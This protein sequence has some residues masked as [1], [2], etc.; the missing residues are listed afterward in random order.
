M[1]SRGANVQACDSTGNGLLAGFFTAYDHLDKV[2]AGMTILLDAGC[3]VN[4]TDLRGITA[5]N[6]AQQGWHRG[7]FDSVA[8]FLI[9]RGART[10]K[11]LLATKKAQRAAAGEPEADGE[12]A[13]WEKIKEFGSAYRS[14]LKD[15]MKAS[16]VQRQ[17]NMC[18]GRMVRPSPGLLGQ[19]AASFREIKLSHLSIRT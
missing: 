17:I 19:V 7:K 15:L 2:I 11:E 14:G 13:S 6:N 5:L 4:A 18:L 12:A 1:V 3:D 16:S 8:Q 9:G 10:K